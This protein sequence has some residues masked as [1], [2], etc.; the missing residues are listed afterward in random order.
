MVEY[1]DELKQKF[2]DVINKA[3]RQATLTNAEASM[4]FFWKRHAEEP[5]F[6]FALRYSK[7]KK[8]KKGT[9]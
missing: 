7:P 2:L 3:N 6:K 1:S 9:K 8:K 4:L 5:Q